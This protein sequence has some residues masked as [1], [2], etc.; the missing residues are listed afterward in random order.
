MR[1]R[2]RRLLLSAAL[3]GVIAPAVGANLWAYWHYREA[4]KAL[5]VRDFAGALRGF[6]RCLTV[7]R[8]STAVHLRAARA[9][10]RAGAFDETERH[11]RACRDLGG[12]EEA[13]DLERML[14]EVQRGRLAEMEPALVNRL[15]RGHPDGVAILEVLALG[16]FQTYQLV[17][18]QDYL[19][20]WLEREPDRPEAWR[21][22]AL[23]YQRLGNRDEALASYRRI[24]EL[25]PDDDDARLHMAG[26]L[27]SGNRV[28]EALALFEQLRAKQGDTPPVLKGL[29]LCRR[30]LNQP[31]EAR[32]LL[33]AVLADNPRDW[34]A[35]SE[36]GQ[37]VLQYESPAAAEKWFRQ[38]AA[39]APFESEV[40]YS[41]YQCLE[42]L[43]NHREAQEVLARL[44]R[45]E[46]DLA[47]L[48]DVSRA[49]ARVPND[50]ALRREAGV[51]LLRNGLE[52]DGLRWLES[53][54]AKAPLHAATHQA[55]AEYYERAGDAE[56]AAR[57]R[58]LAGGEPAEGDN[59]E[60]RP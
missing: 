2:W 30:S 11:L 26:H 48:A 23:V 52:S 34:R 46:T 44:K 20:R 15:D 24:V 10:R 35:L 37:L 41:L 7:W 16:S 25:D 6:D 14:V 8:S 17:K 59:G 27:A 58:R 39:L 33:E 28:D 36:M 40:N 19:K 50:P 51:I 55:L 49:I 9:A 22:R 42:R 32:R 53:A 29:A 3:L 43:G 57:H 31:D 12:D 56:R 38:A 4:Q 1:K 21:L 45:V 18:A 60:A 47:R 5:Q 13:I 54:L